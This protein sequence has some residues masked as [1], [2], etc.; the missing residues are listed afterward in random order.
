MAD[1]PG[2]ASRGASPVGVTGS[3]SLDER[4]MI[5]SVTDYAILLLDPEGVVRSWNAGAA[6]MTG[7][8]SGEMIGQPVSKLYPPEL[9]EVGWAARELREAMAQGRFEDEGWR[10]RKDGSRFR[11][12]EVL[13]RAAD[14]EGRLVG[15]TKIMRDM[16]D[17]LTQDELLRLSEERFR[18]LV[19]GVKDYAIF[20]LDPSGRIISWNAG[21]QKNKGYEAH[22]AI[23]AH[24]SIFYPEEANKREWPAEELRRALADGR[25]EEEGWRLRKG[26]ERFWASVVITPLYDH[27]SRH[28]GFAKVT[29]DLTDRRRIHRLEDEGRR[30]STFLAMLGHELRNPLAPISYAL[31]V[32]ERQEGRTAMV[33]RMHEVI[34]RQLKQMSRLVDDLLEVGRITNGKIRLNRKP[35][36]LRD[37]ALEAVEVAMPMVHG[38]AQELKID[39]DQASDLWVEADHAR[40]VQVVSNVL[41]NAAKFTPKGGQIELTL[42]G[43]RGMAEICVK[44]NGVGIAADLLDSLFDLFVQGDQGLAHAEGGL[45]LG[46][47]L[48]RNL[49]ALH[50]GDVAAFSAGRPGEGSEFRIR[51]PQIERPHLEP[52]SAAAVSARSTRKRILVADD[53][54]DT[55][56]MLVDLLNSL[57]Y[58]ASAVYCGKDAIENIRTCKPD[59]AILDIGMPDISGLEVC[60]DV[61]ADSSIPTRLVAVTGYGVDADREATQAVG[62]DAHLTKPV[63]LKLLASLLESVTA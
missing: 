26:G 52:S 39:L 49:I 45:G 17:R 29:R 5:E 41:V 28:I 47:T 6:R 38:K 51:L 53:N 9:M 24:F 58:E 22:E 30:I 23:G 11:V 36:L 1:T 33:V 59:A 32:L 7:F 54:Q 63:S 14:A 3:S 43:R 56:N 12:A 25:Y 15:Y 50:G 34:G 20:M 61:R 37:A 48:V 55:A 2:A 46:L 57:N 62:F 4:L 19:D 42:F 27:L 35:M 18:L 16:S 60:R 8:S 44:D 10:M 21:A 13:Y 40:L 31:S